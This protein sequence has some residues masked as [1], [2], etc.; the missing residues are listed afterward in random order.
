MPASPVAANLLLP[1]ENATERTGFARPARCQLRSPHGRV[2]INGHTRQ[3]E[4][5][6]AR[7]VVKDVDGS[8]LVPTRRVHAVPAQVDAHAKASRA[9]AS[10]LVLLDL[11][12]VLTRNVPDVDSAIVGRG[13]QVASIFAQRQRPGFTG[14]V[15]QGGDLAAETPLA[16]VAVERP[17]LHLTAETSAGG[18]AAIPGGG[19]VM[20]A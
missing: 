13:S 7:F 16:G 10:R 5:D 12:P 19:D 6:P 15:G 11:G 1:G 4:Q 8:V 17:D 20:T 18:D 3:G 2:W 14:L 9:R